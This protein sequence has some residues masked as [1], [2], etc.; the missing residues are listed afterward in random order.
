MD[1]DL[2]HSITITEAIKDSMEMDRVKDGI[3]ITQIRI[4]VIIKIKDGMV[5]GK[6]RIRDEIIKAKEP[7]HMVRQMKLLDGIIRVNKAGV[8][9][10]IKIKAGQ[11][12]A[13]IKAGI[14]KANKAG[15]ISHMVVTATA[16]AI[17]TVE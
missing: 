7:I 17:K 4:G 2:R 15:I 1:L 14:V 12:K 3:I 5:K 10:N 13:K 11:V 16:M 8:S 9:N 6:I